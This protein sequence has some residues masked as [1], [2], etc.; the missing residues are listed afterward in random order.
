MLD[1]EQ[2]LQLDLLALHAATRSSQDL[3]WSAQGSLRHGAIDSAA[4]QLHLSCLET[5][6]VSVAT[7]L[8]ARPAFLP[9]AMQLFKQVRTLLHRPSLLSAWQGTRCTT[10]MASQAKNCFL[11]GV[12]SRRIL[13]REFDLL[14]CT[15][16]PA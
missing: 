16:T 4:V 8:P 14:R 10:H 15:C 9:Q 11:L 3:A 1:W 5:L 7:P 2:R 12:G 13:S 6:L